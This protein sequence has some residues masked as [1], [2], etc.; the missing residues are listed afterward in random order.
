MYKAL[1]ALPLLLIAACHL[2]DKK[3]ET[4]TQDTTVTNYDTVNTASLPPQNNKVEKEIVTPEVGDS[5]LIIGNF[6]GDNISDSGYLVLVDKHVTVFDPKDYEHGEDNHLDSVTYDY[7]FCFRGEKIEA[8]S[9]LGG[10][11]VMLVNEGDINHDGKDEISVLHQYL[12]TGMCA[13]RSYTYQE[14]KW[15]ELVSFEFNGYSAA[16]SQE[17]VQYLLLMKDSTPY[18]YEHDDSLGEKL[19]LK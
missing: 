8:L 9:G 6:D 10:A 5:M 4:V 17:E 14:G 3:T 15:K 2:S 12:Q 18:F 11:A 7:K 1:Y 16:L 19:E 13:F